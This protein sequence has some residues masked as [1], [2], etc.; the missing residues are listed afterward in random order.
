MIR[1]HS[2]SI[3]FTVTN[4]P[5]VA[6]SG[7]RFVFAQMRVGQYKMREQNEKIRCATAWLVRR[8]AAPAGGL[9]AAYDPANGQAYRSGNPLRA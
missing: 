1:D 6:F 3:K 4:D 5:E 7:A 8:P 2:Q 9:R